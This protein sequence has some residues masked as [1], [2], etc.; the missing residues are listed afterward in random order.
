MISVVPKSTFTN[1]S[2]FPMVMVF[3]TPT[4]I[5]SVLSRFPPL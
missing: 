3:P 2:A 5:W 4:A 1:I